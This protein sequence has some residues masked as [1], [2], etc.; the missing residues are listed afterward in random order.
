MQN[1]WPCR[2]RQNGRTNRYQTRI[3]LSLYTFLFFVIVH[4]FFFFRKSKKLFGDK[5]SFIGFAVVE[6]ICDTAW[7]IRKIYGIMGIQ[8]SRDIDETSVTLRTRIFQLILSTIR[9]FLG[10]I[11]ISFS[12]NYSQLRTISH[13]DNSN[14]SVNPFNDTMFLRL[15]KDFFFI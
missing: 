4:V 11:K 1:A 13:F 14:I 2:E 8:G 12:I 9:C 3:F 6:F 10:Y 7:Q 5:W 15:H